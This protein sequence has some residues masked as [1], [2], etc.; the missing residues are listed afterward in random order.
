MEI[1][2]LVVEQVADRKD[3]FAR[4]RGVGK[5]NIFASSVNSKDGGFFSHR[6]LV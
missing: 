3:D 1:N 2:H 5:S 6:L 4:K